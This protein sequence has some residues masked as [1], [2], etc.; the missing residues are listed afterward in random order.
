[1]AVLVR[2]VVVVT[3]GEDAR[4]TTV[5]VV[6]LHVGLR[7]RARVALGLGRRDGLVDR[8]LWRWNGLV[9]GLKPAGKVLIRDLMIDK[10]PPTTTHLYLSDVSLLWPG[11]EVAA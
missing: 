10:K 7:L 11:D 2:H 9:V 5:H 3:I 8:C 4:G 6:A 1:V